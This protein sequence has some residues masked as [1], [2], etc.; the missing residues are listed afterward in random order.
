MYNGNLIGKISWPISD[1]YGNSFTGAIY[2]Q[3]LFGRIIYEKDVFS[4]D[5]DNI[6]EIYEVIASQRHGKYSSRLS[7]GKLYNE[8]WRH[9]IYIAGKE[10]KSESELYFNLAD[11]SINTALDHDWKD[12]VKLIS[13]K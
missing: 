5:K 12:K 6:V 2:K 4:V 9:G 7:D 11:G 1:I 10:V 13:R 8:V 3:L